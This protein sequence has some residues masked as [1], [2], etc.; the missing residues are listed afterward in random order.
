MNNIF[1][2]ALYG[3]AIGFA[4]RRPRQYRLRDC[5]LLDVYTDKEIRD[6]FRFRRDS[7]D[8]IVDLLYLDLVRHTN[9]NHALSVKTQVLIALRF[10]ASGSFQQVIGDIIGVDKSTV[11]RTVYKFCKAIIRHK[12]QFIQFPFTEDEKDIIK[13]GFYKIGGFPSTIACIDGTHIRISGPWQN[14]N[15]FVNRKG[16]HSINVQGMTDHTGK[17]VDVVSKWPGS[18]HDSFVFRTSNI[19]HY[20]DVTNTTIDKGIILGDSGYA[21]TNYLM[22]PY[23]NPVT[24]AQRHFNRAQKTTRCSVERAFGQLKRRFFCLHGGLRVQPERACIIIGACSI[25]HNIAIIRNEEPFDD[26]MEDEFDCDPYAGPRNNN[27]NVVR[28]HIAE[29]FFV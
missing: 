11:S 12:Q 13:Q 1:N 4:R 14:E 18:T 8:F 23:A 15:D 9:R 7:I 17:F 21:L 16:Y 26:D 19:K 24:P 3:N 5:P 22:T 27:G 29:T 10:F 28:D 6:R 2:A 25:L 20:L